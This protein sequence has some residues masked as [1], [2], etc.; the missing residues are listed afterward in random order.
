VDLTRPIDITAVNDTRIE[1]GD[2]L[3]GLN[4]LMAQDILQDCFPALGI[5]HSRMVGNVEHGTI[6]SKYDGIFHG[7]KKI[8][9]LVPRVLTVYPVVAEMSDEPERYRNT[10]IADVAGNLWAKNLPFELWLIQFGISVASEE[11][12]Y[13]LFPAKRNEGAGHKSV[14]DSFDGWFTVIDDDITAGRISA[15]NHNLYA[16]GPIT[17]ANAGDYLLA[18]WRSR[19]ETLRNKATTL[20][21]SEDVGDLYDDWYRD[22]HDSPPNI[23]TAGQQF[24]DGSNGRVRV[25]RTGA[26]PTGSQRVFITTR[27][28]MLYGTDKLEDMKAMQAFNSG[29]PYRFTAAMKFV[30]GTQ[31]ASVNEREFAVNDRSGSGSGSTSA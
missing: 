12:Y 14:N 13:S 26:I 19:H 8:G 4:T 10:F 30:F 7:D 11:L 22:E 5:Q 17:R 15:A 29:N 20:W 6:L 16:D 3:K 21:M 24:L 28:N 31:F 23:D 18:M 1:Y 2:L 25:R 9:T 27:P